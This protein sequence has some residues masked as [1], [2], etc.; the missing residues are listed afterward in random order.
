M[1]ETN[2]LPEGYHQKITENLSDYVQWTRPGLKI[3]RLRLLSDLG[4]PFWDVS[5]CHG[6]LPDG[7]YVNVLLPFSRLRKDQPL[8]VQLVEWARR[9]K[10]FLK[11]TGIFSA[12]STL[13]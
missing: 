4:H 3:L 1:N 7:R 13:C 6:Q 2:P 11:P 5:Y 8:N 10:V 12:I 9:D